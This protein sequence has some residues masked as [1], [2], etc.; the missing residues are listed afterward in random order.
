MNTINLIKRYTR[1]GRSLTWIINNVR[2]THDYYYTL[3]EDDKLMT[4]KKNFIMTHYT[5][6]RNKINKYGG[7]EIG[8]FTGYYEGM[9]ELTIASGPTYSLNDLSDNELFL[10]KAKEHN[11][12][13]QL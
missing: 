6:E 12:L 13:K 9:H 4:N 2:T 10:F 8:T 5:D 3:C 7:A 1:Q 11:K